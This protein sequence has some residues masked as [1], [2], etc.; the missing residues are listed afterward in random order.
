MQQNFLKDDNRVQVPHNRNGP[1]FSIQMIK[2]GKTKFQ[3]HASIMKYSSIKRNFVMQ[4]PENSCFG[5]TY[6][7]HF[8]KKTLYLTHMVTNSS[9][10]KSDSQQQRDHCFCIYGL[11]LP[12]AQKNNTGWQK[13]GKVCE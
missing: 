10:Y 6:K 13:L 1:A 3:Y 12:R 5:D 2:G 9:S 11:T 8:K 7:F 4:K